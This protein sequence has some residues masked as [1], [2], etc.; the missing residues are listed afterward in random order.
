M[1]CNCDFNLK[2]M[3]RY[4][5]LSHLYSILYN[6]YDSCAHGINRT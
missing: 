6:N 3:T 5:L 2:Y 4:F 1:Y